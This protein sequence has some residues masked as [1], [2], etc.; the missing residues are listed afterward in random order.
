MKD[1]AGESGF[2]HIENLD[3]FRLCP[4]DPDPD[5]ARR[6]CCPYPATFRS[7]IRPLHCFLFWA[8][9]LHRSNHS[10]SHFFADI[11]GGLICFFTSSRTILR[12]VLRMPPG[13]LFQ[14]SPFSNSSA[15]FG[16]SDGFIW[17]TCPS[18]RK[19][20]VWIVVARESHFAMVV[21]LSAGRSCP[22]WR[23]RRRHRFSK[24]CKLFI[25]EFFAGQL[26]Q[27]YKS[28]LRTHAL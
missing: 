9:S 6:Q 20:L 27:P 7:R 16:I 5:R 23:I 2:L 12:Q 28:T 18:H 17:R 4:P 19:R 1:F 21:I 14:L 10:V 25:S 26:S 13:G 24:D 15:A 11:F 3:L 22:L 8:V